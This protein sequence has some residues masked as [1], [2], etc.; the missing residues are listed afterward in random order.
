MTKY[1]LLLLILGSSYYTF[2][3]GK[4]LW[5]D[6]HN[7]LGGFGASVIAFLAVAASVLFFFWKSD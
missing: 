2:T 1:F 4:S 5:V 3:F 7:K 6:D